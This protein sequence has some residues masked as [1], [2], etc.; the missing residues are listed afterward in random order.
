[1]SIEN[2]E[3]IKN[4]KIEPYKTTVGQLK[5]FLNDNFPD[6]NSEIEFEDYQNHSIILTIVHYFKDNSLKLHIGGIS[7]TFFEEKCQYDPKLDPF[8]LKKLCDDWVENQNAKLVVD[9]TM[10]T[11]IDIAKSNSL[12]IDPEA[13]IISD[14]QEEVLNTVLNFTPDDQVE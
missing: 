12:E 10:P 13:D 3:F 6:D 11:S 9:T 4:M 2:R 14:N 1:M 7:D 5:Q 8:I